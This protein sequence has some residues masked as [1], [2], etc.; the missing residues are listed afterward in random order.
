MAEITVMVVDD[1]PIWR[2]AVSRDLEE[3]GFLVVAEATVCGRP[4]RGPWSNPPLSS[5]TCR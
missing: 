1:H 3:A 2:T 4:E 5:W